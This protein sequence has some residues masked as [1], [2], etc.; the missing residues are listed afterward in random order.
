MKVTLY[1]QNPAYTQIMTDLVAKS[2]SP[3]AAVETNFA[4]DSS[5]FSTSRFIRWYDEKYGC[6]RKKAHWVKA[7]I[8]CGVK[9]NCVTAVRVLDKDSADCP[10]F[11]PLMQET[12][13]TF[14]VNEASADKAY[15]SQESFETVADMGGTAY[16]PFKSSSTG[17]A[18]GL[19]EKMFHYFNFKRD[20]YLA[21]YH[22]RSNVESTFSA[23]KR[24]FGDSVRSVTDAAIVNEVLAKIIC[25]NLCC[26]IQEQ[27][28]LGIAPVFLDRPQ[29]APQSYRSLRKERKIQECGAKPSRPIRAPLRKAF[30]SRLHESRQF[31]LRSAKPSRRGFTSGG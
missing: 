24:K 25:H 30:A 15:V 7:H 10:Q 17:A 20:E 14:E 12:A 8:A 9:T 3:L 11:K 29:D 28:E 22:K 19:F 16:I 1:T 18:G 13:E 5:G 26:L 21:H 6:E 2:A 31:A 4:V 23:I 27:E